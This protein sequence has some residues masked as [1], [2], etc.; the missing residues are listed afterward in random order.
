MYESMR[1]AT[2][3][4]YE[5]EHGDPRQPVGIEGSWNDAQ[6]ISAALAV[7]EAGWMPVMDGD[8]LLT[9]SI[10]TVQVQFQLPET[11]LSTPFVTQVE[12]IGATMTFLTDGGEPDQ[13]RHPVPLEPSLYLGGDETGMIVLHTGEVGLDQ[14]SLAEILFDAYQGSVREDEYTEWDDLKHEFRELENRMTDVAT[15]ILEGNEAGL[16]A[17]MHTHAH[18]FDP[19]PFRFPEREITVTGQDGSVRLTVSPKA[20][21]L[22]AA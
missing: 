15:A 19:G 11:G 10:P 13:N 3:A 6:N 18:R 21:G 4:I 12:H 17:R 1:D 22:K 5:R 2:A 9:S 20:D 8:N 14:D 7:Q 16:T